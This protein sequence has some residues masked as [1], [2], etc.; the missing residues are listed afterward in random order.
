MLTASL[1]TLYGEDAQTSC[2]WI[3]NAGLV[4]CGAYCFPRGFSIAW[5][6]YA[7]FNG[8]YIDLGT[9]QM[10]NHH[11][12]W[13]P[14]YVFSFSWAKSAR[15]MQN[16]YPTLLSCHWLRLDA[17]LRRRRRQWR[18]LSETVFLPR[19]PRREKSVQWMKPA[20]A[21]GGHEPSFSRSGQG[22]RSVVFG[23]PWK[24]ISVRNY[25]RRYHGHEGSL[26]QIISP[27]AL[28]RRR[29]VNGASWNE[30][31][32]GSIETCIPRPWLSARSQ[33][34]CM[35]SGCL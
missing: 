15:S 29:L 13:N 30:R 33:S 2:S 28:S 12:I 26:G 22:E 23:T 32:H 5:L 11:D 9:P 31:A 7:G 34:V 19:K 8:R 1:P 17:R 3:P 10:I 21:Q 4:S 20:W 35:D 16:N 6:I 25:L 14:P 27:R 24:H 18:S